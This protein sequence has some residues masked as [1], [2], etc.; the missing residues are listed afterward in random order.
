MAQV[1]PL[2]RIA[3][4]ALL[5]CGVFLSACGGGGGGSSPPMVMPPPP[6]PT[7]DTQFPVSLLSP[8]AAGCEG[9]PVAG[10]L[11]PNS[12]VEPFVAVNPANAANLI[13]VWQQDRWSNGGA[14][15]LLGASSFDGGRTWTIRMKKGI[16]FTPDPGLWPRRP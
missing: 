3:A 14:K 5:C 6:D 15:G 16:R 7:P 12:E 11:Y 8:F 4:A 1:S 2:S 9:T 10:T 13:G